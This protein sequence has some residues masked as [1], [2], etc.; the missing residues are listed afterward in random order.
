MTRI[1]GHQDG[2]NGGNEHYTYKGQ[3][4]TRPQMVKKVENEGLGAHIIK[5][6]GKKYVRDNPDGTKNDNVNQ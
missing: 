1:R 6:E 2:P 4:Y 5:V 3:V